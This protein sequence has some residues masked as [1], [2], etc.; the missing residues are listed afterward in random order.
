LRA[1]NGNF[2][3]KSRCP[4]VCEGIPAM[5]DNYDSLDTLR[6]MS[7]TWQLKKEKGGEEK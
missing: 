1:A 3:N 2:E 4:F 7:T 6:T 5:G